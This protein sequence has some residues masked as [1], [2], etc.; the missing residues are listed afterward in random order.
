MKK[1]AFLFLILSIVLFSCK[2]TTPPPTRTQL[3]TDENWFPDGDGFEECEK[4][5]PF[6]FEDDGTFVILIDEGI[7]CDSVPDKQR[8]SG[9]WTFYLDNKL[10]LYYDADELDTFLIENL[11][12][13][14][15]ILYSGVGDSLIFKH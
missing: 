15:L 14:Q 13:E 5:D 2:E 9:F 6:D 10:I 11:T 3:L 7:P 8:L 1:S 4:D 12:E